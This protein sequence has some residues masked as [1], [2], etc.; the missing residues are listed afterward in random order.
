LP[1]RA[2]GRTPN[3]VG[4]SLQGTEF[5]AGGGVINL[6]GPLE[7]AGNGSGPVRA[8]R[9]RAD[10]LVGVGPGYVVDLSAIDRVPEFYERVVAAR[11][12]VA[13]IGTGSGTPYTSSLPKGEQFLS[14]AAVPAHDGA[15]LATRGE[16]FSIRVEGDPRHHRLVTAQDADFLASV[17]IH[18]ADRLVISYITV[19][20]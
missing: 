20:N 10:L 9:E 14:G 11:G 19:P 16:P 4:M 7:A 5:L 3:P 12:Q 18:Q 13:A 15:V 17:P 8:E 1:V 2:E 6:G